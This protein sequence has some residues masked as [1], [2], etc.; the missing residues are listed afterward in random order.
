[1][2]KMLKKLILTVFLS[3]FMVGTA[4]A[5]Y[6]EIS[7][8]ALSGGYYLASVDFNFETG[9]TA[10]SMNLSSQSLVL[11]WAG[12]TN[13]TT[14][15]VPE[16]G[17]TKNPQWEAVA[18]PW[19]TA[20][21]GL[22]TIA[23][24]VFCAEPLANPGNMYPPD[25]GIT[26][27]LWFGTTDPGDVQFGSYL[28]GGIIE[29]QK[30]MIDGTELVLGAGPPNGLVLASGNHQLTPIP[31]PGAIYLLASGL[32]GLIGLRRRIK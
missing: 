11:T 17:G 28:L 14:L 6:L 19:G 23:Y 16:Y 30:L 5:W 2:F 9:E 22:G 21:G 32:I 25:D 8:P 1:M 31:I 4:N 15:S 24:A 3:L 7:T 27:Y 26:A 18:L 10:G 29:Q 12:S 13:L 20:S